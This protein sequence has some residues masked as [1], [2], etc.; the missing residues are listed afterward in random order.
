MIQLRFKHQ[1]MEKLYRDNSYHDPRLPNEL[2]RSYIKKCF[3][4]ETLNTISDLKH[5]TGLK[6]EHYQNY[7]SIRINKQRRITFDYDKHWNITI[8]E[9]IDATNHYKANFNR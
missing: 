4:L 8:I 3:I 9:V 5:Y 6:F 2:R 1:A 7:Y